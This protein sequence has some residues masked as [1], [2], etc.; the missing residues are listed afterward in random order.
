[1]LD[2][3]YLLSLTGAFVVTSAVYSV[4]HQLRPTLPRAITALAVAELVVW[5]GGISQAHL[6]PQGAI[7]I[8]LTGVVVAAASLGGPSGALDSGTE[9]KGTGRSP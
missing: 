6:T 4:V 8:T 5:V 2:A 7:L 9:R 1:M 3:P